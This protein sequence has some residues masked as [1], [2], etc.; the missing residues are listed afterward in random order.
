MLSSPI[1]EGSPM[2]TR[3]TPL[4]RRRLLTG[5][6]IVTV[7]A[8][9]GSS[10]LWSRA[11]SPDD[12]HGLFLLRLRARRKKF[13]RGCGPATNATCG[14]ISISATTDGGQSAALKSLPPS[15]PMRLSLPAPIHEFRWRS[16]SAPDWDLFVVRV[17][18]NIVDPKYLGVLGSIAITRSRNSKYHSSSCWAMKA[19]RWSKPQFE[20]CSK[21]NNL[22]ALSVS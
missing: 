20:L 15:I 8:A 17:A 5:V 10:A 4:T 13:S 12:H 18:G 9:V 2:L 16:Y 3:I 14:S 1:P 6:G 22:R 19:A 7:G 21:A 11:D